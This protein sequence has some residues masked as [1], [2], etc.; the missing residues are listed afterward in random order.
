MS[1][2]KLT[3]WQRRRLQNRLLQAHDAHLYRRILAVLEFDGGRSAADIARLLRVSR[4]SVYH[5]VDAYTR[6]HDPDVLADLQRQGR[7]RLLERDQERLLQSLLSVPPQELGLPH[8]SWS[9]P[10]L[11]QALE[12]V[13]GRQVS[14]WTMRRALHRLGYAWKRPRYVLEPDPDLEKKSGASAAKSGACRHA[15]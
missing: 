8:A 13:D 1:H 15:V 5:W 3:G 2:L 9:V 12:A 14:F 7:P 10:L 6:S 11:L 4:Q